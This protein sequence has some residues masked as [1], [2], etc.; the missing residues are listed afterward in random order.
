MGKSVGAACKGAL[1]MGWWKSV[2][3]TKKF[4]KKV[5]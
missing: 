4:P 1:R 5:A 2:V 3:G